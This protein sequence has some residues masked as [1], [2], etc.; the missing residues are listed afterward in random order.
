MSDLRRMITSLQR[1]GADVH[2]GGRH[3]V[4]RHRGQVVG[5][6]PKSLRETPG[7]AHQNT[8]AQLRR[9]GYVV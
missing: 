8:L 7:R 4:I 5:V 9:A 1:Q 2:Y 6:L 3:I